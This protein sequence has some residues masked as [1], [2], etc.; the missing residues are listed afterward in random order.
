[1]HEYVMLSVVVELYVHTPCRE[2][3]AITTH[4]KLEEK[5]KKLFRGF[6]DISARLTGKPIEQRTKN[7]TIGFGEYFSMITNGLMFSF[8]LLVVGMLLGPIYFLAI[9]PFEWLKKRLSSIRIN[10]PEKS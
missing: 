10:V 2:G 5:M 1:M 6:L 7:G 8:S 4:Q 3:I 9:R